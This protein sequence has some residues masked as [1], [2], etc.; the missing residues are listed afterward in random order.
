[1]SHISFNIL[2]TSIAAKAR[3]AFAAM[4]VLLCVSCSSNDVIEEIKE[5]DATGTDPMRFTRAEVVQSDALTR[6]GNSLKTG[7][8]VS[9]YKSFG[10]AAAQQEVM[11]KYMVEHRS[12]G[13]DWDGNTADNWEYV[14][15]SG[16]IERYW[17]N[18]SFP[19]RFNAVAPTDPNQQLPVADNIVLTDKNLTII[20]DFKNQTCTNGVVTPD[21]I[22]AEPYMVAQVQRGSDGKDTDI[23]A[24][25]EIAGTNTTL[26][27]YVALPFH[28]LNS[29]VRFGVYTLNTWAAN[30]KT[31][32]EDLVIKISSQ[33][34]V[35]KASSYQINDNNGSWKVATVNSGFQGLTKSS[36][37]G[38]EIFRFKGLDINNTPFEDND[39]RKHQ[40]QSSAYMMDCKN[41]IM[42]I[43]QEDVQMTASLTLKDENGGEL[44]KYE[45]IPI[46]LKTDNDTQQEKFNWVSGNIYTYYLIL[47]F[48]KQLEIEFTA[49]LAP[50]EDISGSLSTDLEK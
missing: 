15:I 20:K 42:Q 38:V 6:A 39:L 7:F 22:I 3:Y 28:H 4:G 23:F 43:P 30:N 41:G 35:T 48:D 36:T 44:K 1:M 10:N 29:K 24:G 25:S 19:Y 45:N 50:W 18:N 14:G 2:H 16:Q 37:T 32:I 17:D 12:A 8:L 47:D 46:V 27:R 13:S 31:Y 33:D 26:T 34:F 9:C 40:G 11:G 5:I 49:T 21:D